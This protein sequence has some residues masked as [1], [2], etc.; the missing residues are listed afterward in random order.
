M[1]TA[2]VTHQDIANSINMTRETASRALGLLFEEELLGQDDHLFTILDMAKLQAE[3][4][5]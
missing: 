5:L 1:I 4:G 3:L 2:P